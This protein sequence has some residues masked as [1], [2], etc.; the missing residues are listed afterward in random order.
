VRRRF[1]F[2]HTPPRP[3]LLHARSNLVKNVGT[4]KLSAVLEAINER[5]LAIG[6]PPDRL[7]GH[8]YF[9]I[10]EN[11]VDDE[12]AAVADRLRWDILPLVEEYC[13]SDREQVSRVLGDLVDKY[14]R[15]NDAVLDSPDAF[16]KALQA[17][18]SG[19]GPT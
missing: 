1:A 4:V 19:D 3:D 16:V 10:E 6:M 2:I 14:G 18:V 5:L 9:W 7:I 11:K 12:V 17:L 15:P 13:F 8:A